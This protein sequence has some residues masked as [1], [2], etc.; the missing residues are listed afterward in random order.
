MVAKIALMKK[1]IVTTTNT[2]GTKHVFF[3]QDNI[4]AQGELDDWEKIE[5][6]LYQ[7]QTEFHEKITEIFNQLQTRHFKQVSKTNKDT[8]QNELL[9]KH[10]SKI[11]HLVLHCP[12]K[13]TPDKWKNV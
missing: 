8:K 2:N 7:T 13:K 3:A 1:M 6:Q 9:S 5:A 10:C 12:H 4:M 11:N